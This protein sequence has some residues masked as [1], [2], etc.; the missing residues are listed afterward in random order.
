MNDNKCKHDW[1]PAWDHNFCTKCG[2]I[3][4]G[5]HFDAWGIAARKVFPNKAAAEFYKENGRMVE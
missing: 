5:P 1:N 3:L 2:S 4:T